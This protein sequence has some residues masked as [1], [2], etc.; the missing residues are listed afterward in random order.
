[1]IDFRADL[2]IHSVLSP[3][4]DLDMSPSRIISEA[5]KKGLDIIGVTDHN[6]IRHCN[7]IMELGKENGIFVLP[8]AEVNTRE[9][10]HCLTFFESIFQLEIFQK[11]LDQN[12]PDIQNDPALFGHQVEV[13]RNEEIIYEEKKSL[14]SSIDQSLEQV[15][16]K[17]KD[18]NG[19]FIP[20]HVDRNKNSIY[21]QLGFLPSGL[22]P[23]AIEVSWRTE[24]NDFLKKHEELKAYTIITSSDAHFPE[25]IAR[26]WSIFRMK[27]RSFAEIKLALQMKTGRKVIIP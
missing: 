4:G 27:E 9:E 10:V 26:V 2:H 8:G 24:I 16:D 25:D 15:Y 18:L 14:F 23:D 20:A 12:L 17:V 11:Y 13:N 7:L 22:D 21:S 19:I 6:T 5:G 3:C 1:M